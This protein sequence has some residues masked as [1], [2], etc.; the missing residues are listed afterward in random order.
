MDNPSI[1]MCYDEALGSRLAG[2][3]RERTPNI[4]YAEILRVEDVELKRSITQAAS[5][6]ANAA[7]R[8]TNIAT[9][10]NPPPA[11]TNVKGRKKGKWRA[12]KWPRPDQ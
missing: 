1:A 4:D 6:N 5:N 7:H 10:T 12:K 9:A 8:L 3:A 2:F 11:E